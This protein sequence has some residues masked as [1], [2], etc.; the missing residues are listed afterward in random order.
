MSRHLYDIEKIMDT[1]FGKSIEVREL[2]ENV[3]RH[4][5]VFNKIEGIDYKMHNPSL[6]SFI[7][8]EN[9]IADWK[10]DY[11][12]MQKHFIHDVHSLTF[13][14]LMKRMKELMERLRNI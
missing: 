5:S 9:A 1:E 4:R 6:L 14:E 8:P 13:E 2:Y 12:S 10:K 3:V 7:P 11:E